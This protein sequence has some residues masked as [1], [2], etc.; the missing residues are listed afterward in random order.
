MTNQ[1]LRFSIAV[2]C[3]QLVAA[4]FFVAESIVDASQAGDGEGLALSWF[5]V[6]V[7]FAL[8]AGIVVGAALV[9]R[10][11]AEAHRRDQALAM[12]RGALGEVVTA[13]FGQWNFTPSEA[14]VALFA[15]K[16]FSIAEIASLRGSA[17]GTIRAQLSQ[18]YGKAGVGSQPAFV[19]LFIE[20]L[21]A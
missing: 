1:R 2:L 21:L 12:A 9:R 13:R 16:G 10:M 15:L 14:D 11:L 5:E 7:A 3:L 19:A 6:G 18:V 17:E 20:E 8:L 4:A